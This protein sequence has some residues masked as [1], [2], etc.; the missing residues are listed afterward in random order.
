MV[1]VK[2]PRNELN[3]QAAIAAWDKRVAD[4]NKAGG[5]KETGLDWTTLYEWLANHS[6]FKYPKA[7]LDY[8]KCWYSEMPVGGKKGKELEHFRPKAAATP[9]TVKQVEKLQK[10]FPDV[11]AL[12]LFDT[13]ASAGYPWLEY[14]ERY[15]YR[16]SSPHCNTGGSKGTVFPIL[17]GTARIKSPKC[18]KPGDYDEYYLLLDP[19]AFKDT[20]L[21]LVDAD[22]M[23]RPKF[24]AAAPGTWHINP[25]SHWDDT[26]IKYCRAAITIVVLDLNHL[27][28]VNARK[29]KYVEAKNY[30][31][32]LGNVM[33]YDLPQTAMQLCISD[34]TSDIF[35][36]IAGAALF[37][38][39]AR[40]ACYDFIDLGNKKMPAAVVI[41]VKGILT[42]LMD[43]V[44]QLE[45]C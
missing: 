43:E 15:N 42:K 31:E 16:L 5:A 32:R 28:L 24:K 14:E 2:Y 17:N 10:E 12:N 29:I 23:I 40:S 20:G 45:R 18:S 35:R 39:A 6:Y 27:D 3:T 38:L 37:S 4:N 34:V 41:A 33:Q 22:G 9:L 30:I 11:A 13:T 26:W 25:V 8:G 19:S 36:L 7:N 1:Y 44:E 21:L